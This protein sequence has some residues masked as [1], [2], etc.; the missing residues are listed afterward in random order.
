MNKFF[1]Y[2]FSAFSFFI[3]FFLIGSIINSNI[4]EMTSD[5]KIAFYQNRLD[6]ITTPI[7][8][9]LAKFNVNEDV[10]KEKLLSNINFKDLF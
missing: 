2:L 9:Y 3:F 10:L 6:I 7:L 4:I 1:S 8:D 5:K